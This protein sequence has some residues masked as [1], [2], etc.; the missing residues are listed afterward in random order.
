VILGLA[1]ALAAAVCYGFGSILQAV[2]ASRSTVTVRL[3]LVLLARLVAQWRYVCGLG[4]DLVG[5]VAAVVALRT[6]PLFV[7]QAAVAGSVGV[8]AL[9]AGWLL[10]THLVRLERRALAGLVVGLVL[11]AAA[12]RPAHASRLAAPGPALLLAGAVALALVSLAP[13]RSSGGRAAAVFA[14]G[15]GVGFGGVGVAAR[16][17]AMPH[18]WTRLLAD[19]LPYA[20]ALYG[21]VATVLFAR[22]LQCGKVT[23]VAA[24]TFSVETV[25]PAVIGVVWL[26]DHART[27]MAPVAVVGFVLTVVAAIVLARFAEPVPQA[28][29]P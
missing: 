13:V 15:A 4:L 3:D 22:A 28:P 10:H 27:G 11:L 12:G 29:V 7:V 2:A 25:L 5:F 8:T 26:G 16:A 1:C 24:V 21:L 18:H 17:F 23:T 14:A 9:A 19:P 6:L 20:I